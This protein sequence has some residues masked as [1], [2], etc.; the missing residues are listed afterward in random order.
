MVPYPDPVVIDVLNDLD[1]PEIDGR[2]STV[3]DPVLPALRIAKVGDL[4]EPSPW[5]ATPLYQ[6]EVWAADELEAGRLAWDLRHAWPRYRRE[7][8]GDAL[9]TARWVEVNPRSFPD[10]DNDITADSGTDLA[11]YILTVGLRLSGAPAT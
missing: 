2:I 10:T 5:E 3:L 1:F 4:E 11:R 7:V 9:V 8:V 6:I